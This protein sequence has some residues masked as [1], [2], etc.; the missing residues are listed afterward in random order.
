M[1]ARRE[2]GPDYYARFYRDEPRSVG[3]PETT[4]RLVRF[5]GS[6]LAHLEVDVREVLDLGC[7]LGWW[8]APVETSMGA[9]W[10]GV[11]WSEHAC[12]EHGW[13][14]GSVV[15]YG[16]SGADLVVCQGVL[17]YLG[18][19]DCDRALRNLQRLARSAIYLEVVTEEDWESTLDLTRSD[20]DIALRPAEYYRSAL[21]KHF[22][23]CGGGLFVR[24]NE[25]VL[26]ALEEGAP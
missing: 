12:A 4:E 1:K 19:K 22:V 13:E 20:R 11:E 23:S 15:D 9:T 26:F 8:K 16:G 24:R 18:K 17:Q 6:Y 3:T 25:C 10:R 14:R 7:G 21:R 5:I 2:F